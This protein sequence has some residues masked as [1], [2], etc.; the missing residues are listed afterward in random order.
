M[1]ETSMS[2]LKVKPLRPRDEP[3]DNAA[4]GEPQAAAAA[5]LAAVTDEIDPAE[6]RRLKQ[7]IQ[8]GED[9]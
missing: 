6:L 4:A 9:E 8:D 2:E 1:S 3:A 5:K 7:L